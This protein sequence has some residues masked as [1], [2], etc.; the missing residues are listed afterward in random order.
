MRWV[1]S[2]MALCAC[3]R[4]HF[5]ERS[6][7]GGDVDSSM[8][9]GPFGPATLITTVLTGFANDDPAISPDGLELYVATMMGAAT[10]DIYVSTRATRGAPWSPLTKVAELSSDTRTD[11]A[12]EL[13]ADGLSLYYLSDNDIV[14]ATRVA[15]GAPWSPQ[16][17][18]IDGPFGTPAVCDD[19]RQLFLRTGDDGAQD[20][21]VTRRDSQSSSWPAPE[22]VPEL[23]TA[24]DESA[25]WLTADCGRIY[26][27]AVLGPVGRLY[28]ADRLPGTNSYG[29]VTEI[30][31][32]TNV[33]DTVHDPS[34]TR[35]E[36]IMVFARKTDGIDAIW[37]T[38]R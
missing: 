9:L 7:D 13:S 2:L 29:R 10:E 33:S 15:V 6:G 17:T 26:F 36:R 16:L 35:D 37:E 11:K 28:S 12:P 19:Q 4:V 32:F 3:G 22:L 14:E 34:L 21:V 24:A 31:G 27:D 8:S 25:P 1:C 18:G 38:S 30:A 23:N 5:D 20:I